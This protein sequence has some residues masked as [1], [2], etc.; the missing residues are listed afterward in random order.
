MLGGAVLAWANHAALLA[1]GDLGAALDAVAYTQSPR[2]EPPV[3][4]ER[5]NWIAR[6][7]EAKDLVAFSVGD[8]YT[9]A[10][11]KLGLR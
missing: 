3:A 2:G 6:T 11:S 10:R 9:E 8:G 5:A 4:A 7:P 1:V